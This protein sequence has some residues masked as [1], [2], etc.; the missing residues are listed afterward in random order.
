LLTTIAD[1]TTARQLKQA[2]A[3]LDAAIKR[4]EVLCSLFGAA[5][6]GR[7]TICNGSK[8]WSRQATCP[9]SNTKRPKARRSGCEASW[10]RNASSAIVISMLWGKR[11]KARGTDEERRWCRPH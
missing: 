7:R 8:K 4:A 5:Q 1:E 10:R 9:W 6:G 2:R 3:D 11:Q